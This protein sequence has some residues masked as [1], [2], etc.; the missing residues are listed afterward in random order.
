MDLTRN[1]GETELQYLWRI[2]Q[3]KD[4]GLIE[5]GWNEI[6]DVMNKE[7]RE[8]EFEYRTESTYRKK[9]TQAREFF[10]AGIFN[11]SQED[12]CSSIDESRYLLEKE[13]VKMRD[14]RNELNRVIREQARREAYIDQIVRAIKDHA[15]VVIPF[16]ENRDNA[17][18]SDSDNSM[19][20]SFSDVHNGI[21][22]ENFCN[23]FNKSVLERRISQYFEKILRTKE[24]HMCGDIHIILSELISGLIHNTLR[25]EANQNVIEQF[26]SIS[27]YLASFISELSYE[28]SNVHVYIAPGN[29]SRV[30]QKKEDDVKGENFD[31][32]ALPF[33]SAKLQN[34]KNVHFHEN[35]IEESIV[36]FGCHG[37][38]VFAVHGDKDSP[39][40]VVQNMTM[41]TSLI[42]TGIKPDI[43]FMFHRHTNGL[44]TVYNSK[45]IQAGCISGSDNFCMDRR[46]GGNPEQV[47][48][49]VNKDGLDCL[50]DV[51]LD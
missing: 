23:I 16:N 45:V 14:E 13:K 6:A 44:K 36:M 41:F 19:I 50:Y 48:A 31:N 15:S 24:T 7:F 4:A 33:L 35:K 2:G 47:I 51:T 12:R 26:L 38:T 39:E 34:F 27:D 25:I 30:N 22:I 1:S 18:L 49:I 3:A 17:H 42:G 40:T 43:V 46:I 11:M 32:L 10:D 37:K 20:I 21:E 28:F 5:S 8:D 9:Y 29:H